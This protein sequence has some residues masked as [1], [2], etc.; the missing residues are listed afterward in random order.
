VAVLASVLR[1]FPT[2]F[3]SQ[4]QKVPPLQNPGLIVGVTDEHN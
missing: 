3:A 1:I 2:A 4:R